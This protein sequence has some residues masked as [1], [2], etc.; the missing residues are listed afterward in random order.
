LT[1]GRAT[2][3]SIS[4][5]PKRLARSALSSSLSMRRPSRQMNSKRARTFCGS[6]SKREAMTASEPLDVAISE[7]TF[8]R[9]LGRSL[10][11]PVVQQSGEENRMEDDPIVGRNLPQATELKV[12]KGRDKIEIP[13]DRTHR[14]ELP[15]PYP[16]D[17]ASGRASTHNGRPSPGLPRPNRR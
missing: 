1:A 14:R 17:L 6:K 9:Y 2:E 16:H 15:L 11:A 5:T 4:T 10:G 12:C 3:S 7:R 13:V 8:R